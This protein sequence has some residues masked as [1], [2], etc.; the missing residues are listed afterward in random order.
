MQDVKESVSE[1]YGETVDQTDDLE[2]NAC[3]VADY[4]SALLEDL[5][6]EVLERRYGCGSPIPALL[7]GQTV[8]DLG[9]G[10]GADCFIASQLVG[11]EGRVIGVDMTDEQLEIARDNVEPHMERFGYDEPNVEFVKGDIEDLPLD[12]GVADVVISN[13]VINLCKDKRAVF[14]EIA[15]ILETGGEFYISDIVADRRVPERLQEDDK[16]WSECLT[17]AAYSEDLRRIM[18]EA[19]FPDVR[20]VKSSPTGDV[21]E[22]I[23]FRSEILRGFKVDLEDRCEDYGQTAVYRGTIPDHELGFALDDHHE[24]RPGEAMRVCR[25]TARM[26][27]ETRFAEHFNVSEPLTHLGLFEDCGEP[28]DADQSAD[29]EAEDE[30]PES[31]EVDDGGGCC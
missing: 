30:L 18:A 7:E 20:T 5:G 8:V 3:C 25:N 12:D 2:F 28:A 17:G 16:L 14:D 4:D 1:Y 24:F 27:T 26:L 22:G 10:A 6:E 15:R 23:R 19:G 13:C 9:C 31:I 21:V 29:V 11:P